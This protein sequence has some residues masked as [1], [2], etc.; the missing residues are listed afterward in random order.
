MPVLLSAGLN[1]VDAQYTDHH[2]NHLL[3]KKLKVFKK[4]RVVTNYFA[5]E[6][7][8]SRSVRGQACAK[9]TKVD[10]AA[11]GSLQGVVQFQEQSPVP[12]RPPRHVFCLNFAG[13]P[14]PLPKRSCRG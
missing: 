5:W 7:N 13:F 6:L 12:A 3:C 4:G 14:G 1:L 2:T 8:R 11:T 10:S 9:K